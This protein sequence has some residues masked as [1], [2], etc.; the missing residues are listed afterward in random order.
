MTVLT[1]H[2]FPRDPER[3]TISSYLTFD[4]GLHVTLGRVDV[5]E[6]HQQLLGRQRAAEV[7]RLRVDPQQSVK[8]L[9][10]ARRMSVR[11]ASTVASLPPL[12]PLLSRLPSHIPHPLHI[13]LPSLPPSI[14]PTSLPPSISP[15]SLPPSPLHTSFTTTGF[16]RV[17]CLS[18]CQSVS[19]PP[20]PR[21][22]Y[23][24]HDHRVQPDEF[25]QCSDHLLLGQ[26]VQHRDQEAD[27]R[28]P[29][30]VQVPDSVHQLR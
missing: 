4:D 17:S 1:P 15:T 11:D 22:P 14:S 5:V 28:H 23:L 6:R 10:E 21:S 24:L 18:V 12:P 8:H 30:L 25:G 2:H 7:T 3:R 13:S 19:L 9:T 29:L 16:S 27:V 20:P 26:P